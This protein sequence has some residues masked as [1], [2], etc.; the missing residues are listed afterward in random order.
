MSNLGV[1]IVILQASVLISAISQIILKKSAQKQYPSVLKEYL[2]L[3]VIIAY[4]LFF[5]STI[6]T[7][8]AL[9]VVPLSLQPILES[10][11]YIYVSIMGF[12]LLKEHFTKR[13]VLGLICIL[14]GVMIYSVNY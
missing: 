7:I 14:L 6:L 8:I 9:R 3:R 1:S 10:T 12:F 11:S 5:V 13:K 4:G 2:N